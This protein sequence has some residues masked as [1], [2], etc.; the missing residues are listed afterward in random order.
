MNKVTIAAKNNQ[1]EVKA[2]YN[3]AFPKPARRLG[4]KWL[5]ELWVFD[6]KEESRVRE[7]CLKVYGTD[8]VIGVGDLVTVRI[9]FLKNFSSRKSGIFFCGRMVASAQSS[10]SGARV[11][12][13]IVFIHGEPE[14]G[15]SYKNWCTVIPEGSIVEI[16]DA[17][18]IA[19]KSCIK[20]LNSGEDCSAEIITESI[21]KEALFA[22]REKLVQ[23]IAEIDARLEGPK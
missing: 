20:K 7:L 11:G 9:E 21:D 10:Y 1:I 23:R 8:G 15:G 16:R 5:N 13:G 19:A 14:S 17:H 12:D 22:E 18:R 4:G 2:P 6:A 3:P